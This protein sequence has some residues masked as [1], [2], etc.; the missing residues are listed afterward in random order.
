MKIKESQRIAKE[1]REKFDRF[2]KQFKT[3]QDFI[4]DL[5]EAYWNRTH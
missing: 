1:I 3:P 4:V 5:M 2:G